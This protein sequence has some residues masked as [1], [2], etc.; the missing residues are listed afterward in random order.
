MRIG[1]RETRIQIRMSGDC[2]GSPWS[3][4]THLW[5]GCGERFAQCCASSGPFQVPIQT[6]I[7]PEMVNGDAL[8]L[9]QAAP[10]GSVNPASKHAESSANT[11]STLAVHTALVQAE[12]H[13][14][15][16]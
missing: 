13:V 15:W 10:C 16:A 1:C 8:P 14:T 2:D 7:G 9:L 3:R 5:S 6:E 4:F 11:L 12:G